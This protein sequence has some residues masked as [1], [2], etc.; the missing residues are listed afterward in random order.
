MDSFIRDSSSQIPRLMTG[1]AMLRNSI[2][3]LSTSSKSPTIFGRKSKESKP[4][5]VDNL[6]EELSKLGT[7]VKELVETHVNLKDTSSPQGKKP[8]G[9]ELLAILDKRLDTTKKVA[10][11]LEKIV[12]DKMADQNTV[13]FSMEK[14][15]EMQ[16]LL[17]DMTDLMKNVKSQIDKSDR[18]LTVLESEKV[19]LTSSVKEMEETIQQYRTKTEKCIKQLAEARYRLQVYDVEMDPTKRHAVLK[20]PEKRDMIR[21]IDL[22]KGQDQEIKKLLKHF[23]EAVE[24][25]EETYKYLIRNTAFAGVSS[26]SDEVKEDTTKSQET[27]KAKNSIM[28]R[29]LSRLSK[30]EE[31]KLSEAD[32]KKPSIETQKSSIR[33][34]PSIPGMDDSRD[35]VAM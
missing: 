35:S 22:E 26:K 14:T 15:I 31:G 11:D 25:L 21:R 33:D 9:E 3:E 16:S 13:V 6:I 28:E 30:T 23:S 24:E 7:L 5:G 17:K 8:P 10:A 4:S 2:T 34:F 27:V 29:S 32:L 1:L 12:D 20:T 19:L 18:T